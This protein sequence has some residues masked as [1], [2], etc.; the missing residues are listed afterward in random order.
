MIGSTGL[1]WRAK[2]IFHRENRSHLELR[3]V[4][5]LRWKLQRQ[6]PPHRQPDNR[7]ARRQHCFFDTFLMAGMYSRGIIP[8]T[9]CFRAAT[10]AAPADEDRFNV[11]Y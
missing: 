9:I 10:V 2:T 11:A 7:R 4:E 3:L 1:V 8:P 6:C 5:S